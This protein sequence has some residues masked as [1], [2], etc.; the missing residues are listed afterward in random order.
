LP[1]GNRKLS[2]SAIPTYVKLVES[3]LDNDPEHKEKFDEMIAEIQRTANEL[4]NV[5]DKVREFIQ[6]QG[7]FYLDLRT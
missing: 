7:K 3:R 4:K 1:S 5:L 2:L 6:T